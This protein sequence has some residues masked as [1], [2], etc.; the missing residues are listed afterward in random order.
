M[1]G[2]RRMRSEVVLALILT[3]SLI[4][5]GAPNHPD[6]DPIPDAPLEGLV[7]EADVP[8]GIDVPDDPEGSNDPKVGVGM[9]LRID[10][11]VPAIGSAPKVPT[12]D[13]SSKGDIPPIS[14]LLNKMV[15]FDVEDRTLDGKGPYGR[16]VVNRV[17]I[18]SPVFNRLLEDAGYAKVREFQPLS[19]PGDW[20]RDSKAFNLPSRGELPAEGFGSVQVK[21][22]YVG[23]AYSDKYHYPDCRWAKNIPPGEQV[24]FSSPEVASARGYAPCGTCRPP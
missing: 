16:M 17:P 7:I 22:F 11:A 13:A 6:L 19:A 2:G 4:S 14:V 15:W 21:R 3:A 10:P 12:P 23:W 8:S 5:I 18:A 1:V 24:W 20:W 9:P